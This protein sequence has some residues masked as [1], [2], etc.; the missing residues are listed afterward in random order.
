MIV[1]SVTSV[2]IS[3][4]ALQ[5]ATG[6]LNSAMTYSYSSW[7]IM[8]SPVKQN[9]CFSHGN[10]M[11]LKVLFD[12]TD[13]LSD[14]PKNK[15]VQFE[16]LRG[17]SPV[18]G[19]CQL[20]LPKVI[21]YAVYSPVLSKTWNLCTKYLCNQSGRSSAL[22]VGPGIFCFIMFHMANCN[23]SLDAIYTVIMDYSCA[24]PIQRCWFGHQHRYQLFA[25][26]MTKY[27]QTAVHI[28]TL[29]LIPVTICSIYRYAKIAG[30]LSSNGKT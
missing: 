5:S 23:K 13:K 1:I 12:I 15:T 24:S 27:Q 19:K 4:A 21:S 2:N 17:C 3:Q 22:G 6:T 28:M 25:V 20:F 18:A 29:S 8:P 14:I 26:K 7:S 16:F 10:V 9:D 30:N 11:I